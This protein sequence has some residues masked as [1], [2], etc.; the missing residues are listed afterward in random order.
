M[1]ALE[2][3]DDG[4]L[5]RIMSGSKLSMEASIAEGEH[6][7]LIVDEM[8][9]ST[10][11]YVENKELVP[12]PPPPNDW[13]NFDYKIK[14]WVPNM[15]LGK[16]L[17]K[18]RIK[19]QYEE[20]SLGGFEWG[21]VLL[22]SDRD[23]QVTIQMTVALGGESAELAMV[24]GACHMVASKEE[25]QDVGRA[26]LDHLASCVRRRAEALQRVNDATTVGELELI[27][28]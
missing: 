2:Y 22:A 8:P 11:A 5:L 3:T 20:A 21:G 15:E 27:Q 18:A 23:S 17:T 25:L 1:N 16:E 6:N 13:H 14:R 7:Y 24:H 28:L 12:M 26:L 9:A 4:Q 10:Y 19:K